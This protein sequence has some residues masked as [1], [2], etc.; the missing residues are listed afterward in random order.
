VHV[1]AE[2]LIISEE[3]KALVFFF[4]DIY[5]GTIEIEEDLQLHYRNIAHYFQDNFQAE[6]DFYLQT[7]VIEPLADS[8]VLNQLKEFYNVSANQ[9]YDVTFHFVRLGHKTNLR[10]KGFS[11]LY[12][13]DGTIKGHFYLVPKHTRQQL[14]LSIIF[15]DEQGFFFDRKQRFEK[16]KLNWF[17]FF[18]NK[19]TFGW[20]F[21][22]MIPTDKYDIGLS[23]KEPPL[24]FRY[25]NK[26]IQYLKGGQKPELLTFDPDLRH[27]K[28]F[29]HDFEVD[30]FL[31]FRQNFKFFYKLPQ[32]NFQALNNL[33]DVNGSKIDSNVFEEQL[34]NKN[35]PIYKH[36]SG[37]NFLMVKKRSLI[38]FNALNANFKAYRPIW[39]IDVNKIK[40]GYT[41][42]L[43]VRNLFSNY[44]YGLKNQK[45]NTGFLNINYRQPVLLEYKF[46]KNC[47]TN[48]RSVG[49]FDNKNIRFSEDIFKDNSFKFN[50]YK[51]FWRMQ[52]PLNSNDLIEFKI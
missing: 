38:D 15:G 23:K 1:E 39:T 29:R 7:K 27:S 33:Y 35:S 34:K 31:I 32:L 20:L 52:K 45:N 25:A 10:Q 43:H 16:K 4:T 50:G 49:L 22:D 37:D 51:N 21:P 47:I 5:L 19:I 28:T 17:Q 36:F 2:E 30:D 26:F 6:L 40:N 42:F 11:I 44:S 41:R 18:V 3:A 46:V 24:R 48:S 8:F 13:P 14:A 12:V 9:V